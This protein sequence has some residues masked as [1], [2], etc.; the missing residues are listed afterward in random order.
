ML[1]SELK[2]SE[3][4]VEVEIK[5]V[6]LFK[7]QD[8]NLL[9]VFEKNSSGHRSLKFLSILYKDSF[10]TKTY[11]EARYYIESMKIFADQKY[12]DLDTD[13]FEV[14]EKKDEKGRTNHT[15]FCKFIKNENVYLSRAKAKT[16]ATV[17]L[18]STFSY[19]KQNVFENNL[20]QFPIHLTRGEVP[21]SVANILD[22]KIVQLQKTSISKEL[23][24][25]LTF[26]LT[27]LYRK[28]E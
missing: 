16:I 19:S 26:I 2:F 28:N 3:D 10:Y 11:S 18:E 21:K 27:N 25:Y 8:F 20:I 1:L 14:R 9:L 5:I 23:K 6:E 4:A 15:F 13:D 24:N 22:N 7:E 12:A 17:F